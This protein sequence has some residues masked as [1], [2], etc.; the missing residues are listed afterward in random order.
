MIGSH[1]GFFL[2]PERVVRAGSRFA[3]DM[4]VL[5]GMAQ[6]RGCGHDNGFGQI[7]KA[8]PLKL[9]WLK[10]PHS[11]GMAG[12]TQEERWVESL[13]LEGCVPSCPS[14]VGRET[15]LETRIL[16]L[17][18]VIAK[19]FRPSLFM[20]AVLFTAAA[21]IGC[22]PPWRDNGGVTQVEVPDVVGKT[23]AAAE[24]AIIAAGLTVGDVFEGYSDSVPE[25][26]VISQA[27]FPGK[28]VRAGSPVILVVSLGAGDFPPP[29]NVGIVLDSDNSVSGVI[30]RDGGSLETIGANSVRYK[31]TIPENAL[32]QSTQITLT[33]VADI[34]GFPFSGGLKA[35]AHLEPSG[36]VLFAP[37]VL[38][39]TH[40]DHP[41][42]GTAAGFAYHADGEDFHLR[43]VEYDGDTARF[44]I[45]H[46][47]GVGHGSGTQQERQ[48]LGQRRPASQQQV[49]D[50]AMAETLDDYTADQQSGEERELTDEEREAIFKIL[51]AR[52]YNT[53]WVRTLEALTNP[54]LLYCALQEYN[55]WKSTVDHHLDQLFPYLGVL[56]QMRLDVAQLLGQGFNNAIQ[57]AAMDCSSGLDPRHAAD[58]V[59]W[60]QVF[61]FSG[62]VFEGGAHVDWGLVDT[63][64]KNCLRF[65]LRFK[66]M[67]EATDVLLVARAS[68]TQHILLELTDYPNMYQMWSDYV[69]RGSG[70]LEY[71]DLDM[72]CLESWVPTPGQIEAVVFPQL[73]VRDLRQCPA[74]P[75]WE[76]LMFRVFIIPSGQLI[77]SVTILCPGDEEPVTLPSSPYWNGLWMLPNESRLAMMDGFLYGEG[78]LF[79]E[80]EWLVQTGRNPI[81]WLDVS[82]TGPDTYA[83]TSMELDHTP[84]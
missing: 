3:S 81:A 64:M 28:V 50:Q 53:V 4:V 60:H 1:L 54:P 71:E 52:Y 74:P 13:R 27:P 18:T 70:I 41:E 67:G 51:Q 84:F 8:H 9:V 77:A 14:V 38:E 17:S 32:A 2:S 45:L 24:S 7:V 62:L 72:E 34:D 48:E 5:D 10:M 19:H 30:S 6:S 37:A 12:L 73:P 22:T 69:L 11:L 31:L 82:D 57:T 36:L 26:S 78:F 40:A 33:P 16:E 42:P 79:N 61:M 44:H 65:E 49:T 66:A 58:M 43:L 39:A 29:L 75:P 46:F 47:S 59:A 35:A 15:A 76:P 21:S 20:F 80:Y 23:Q 68:T 55:L 56:T 83:E 63:F 25:G